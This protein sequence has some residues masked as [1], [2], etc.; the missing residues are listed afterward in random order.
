[1]KGDGL[2]L[3]FLFAVGAFFRQ[4]LFFSRLRPLARL[5]AELL[6]ALDL[7]LKK[8]FIPFFNGFQKE[9]PRPQTVPALGSKS[10]A[11]DV[12]SGWPMP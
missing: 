5:P 9:I 4:H 11:F 10:L 2:T 3:P 12:D 6:Y 8:I 7:F 1:M